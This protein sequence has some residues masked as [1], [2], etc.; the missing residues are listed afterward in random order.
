M[1]LPRSAGLDAPDFTALKREYKHTVCYSVC[2]QGGGCVYPNICGRLLPDVVLVCV[3]AD[4]EW[5]FVCY[6]D[7]L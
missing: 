7:P 6:S 1:P 4:S 3:L 5:L 2:V